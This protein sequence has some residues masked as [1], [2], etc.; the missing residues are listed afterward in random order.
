MRLFASLAHYFATT[1]EKG[2]QIHLYGAA[3]IACELRTGERVAL[4]MATEYPWQGQIRLE[5]K[6]TSSAPWQLSLRRPGWSQEIS[7]SL[8]GKKIA[9]LVEEEGYLT[10]ERSWQTGDVIALNLDMPPMLVESNPRVDATRGC[11]AIQRGPIVYCL[12]SHDQAERENLLD[13]QIDTHQPLQLV[14]RDDLLGGVMTVETAGYVTDNT[15]W[16]GAL[17]RA[18]GQVPTVARRSVRLVAIPYYAWG[19]RG[20][21]S[22]RVWIPKG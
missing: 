22:M 13:V 21:E 17:Y 7:L 15:P 11:V 19:N 6:E 16:Q 5:I 2:I 4:Q 10:L 12:E 18:V 1:D 14:Q 9:P 20:I 3:D 8:N